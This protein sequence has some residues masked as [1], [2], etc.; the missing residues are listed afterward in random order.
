MSSGLLSV[1]RQPGS[2]E[3]WSLKVDAVEDLTVRV[4]S[5][6]TPIFAS[7]KNSGLR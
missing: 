1:D 5:S 7:E 3:V 6:V 4:G 2:Q